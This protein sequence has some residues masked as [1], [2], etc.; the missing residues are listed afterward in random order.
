MNYSK[1][2]TKIN[3]IHTGP[4]GW[5]KKLLQINGEDAVRQY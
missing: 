1:K 3:Q 2:H 5:T 4:R